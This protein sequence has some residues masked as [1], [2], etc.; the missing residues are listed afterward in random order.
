MTFPLSPFAVPSGSF[1]FPVPP[2]TNPVGGCDFLTLTFPSEWQPYILGALQQLT[3]Q[4]TWQGTPDEQAAA[5]ER[6]WAIIAT[7]A[8]ASCPEPSPGGIQVEEDMGIRVDCNCRVFVT[9]CDGTEV[10][11]LTSKNGAPTQPGAGSPLPSPGGGTERYCFQLGPRAA[12]L[13]P[14]L[15]NTGDTILIED[16][17]GAW[18]DGNSLF[19]YCPSGWQFILGTCNAVPI[20]NVG[21]QLVTSRYM[22][23]IAKIGASLFDVLGPDGAG[24][25]TPFTVP[26]GIINQP[27]QFLA[28][29]IA[30]PP[31]LVPGGLVTFCAKVTNNQLQHWTVDL[32]WTIFQQGFSPCI[33]VPGGTPTADYVPGVG[34]QGAFNVE[35]DGQTQLRIFKANTA[36][37]TD[38]RIDGQLAGGPTTVNISDGNATSI[39]SVLQTQVIPDGSFIEEWMGDVTLTDGLRIDVLP[40]SGSTTQQ[41]FAIHIEGIGPNPFV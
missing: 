14:P 11:L 40:V 28:N 12:A 29:F 13:L 16:A 19:W 25:P 3:L 27:L 37:I 26:A 34:W 17:A 18:Q 38:V 20:A 36:R 10:E 31:T 6:A 4:A 7:F 32:D 15:V 21:Q 1:P 8:R 33:T 23:V 39:A 41:L 35:G 22:G 5:M 30:T 9:C 24:N 2:P